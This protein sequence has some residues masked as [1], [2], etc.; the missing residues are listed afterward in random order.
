MKGGQEA[1]LEKQHSNGRRTIQN[2]DKQVGPPRLLDGVELQIFE[3]FPGR[4]S[5][6][7]G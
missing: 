6:A 3:C 4:V 5:L 2:R 7:V 1:G